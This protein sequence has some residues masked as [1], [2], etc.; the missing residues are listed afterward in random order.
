[1][2]GRL[3][4]GAP[5]SATCV[6]VAGFASRV[7]RGNAPCSG[8]RTAHVGHRCSRNRDMKDIG[9]PQTARRPGTAVRQPRMATRDRSSPA[10]RRGGLEAVNLILER[11]SC[12]SPRIDRPT[13]V[14]RRAFPCRRRRAPQTPGPRTTATQGTCSLTQPL[15]HSGPHRVRATPAAFHSPVRVHSE[16]RWR[17]E[18]ACTTVT[19]RT[20]SVIAGV[21]ANDSMSPARRPSVDRDTHT[22][23]FEVAGCDHRR[24][25]CSTRSPHTWSD[26]S[27]FISARHRRVTTCRRPP[28]SESP[29]PGRRPRRGPRRRHRAPRDPRRSP[30]RRR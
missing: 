22:R 30:S 6:V 1:M 20:L 21:S 23:P 7:R 27:G 14:H 4:C 15:L 9:A 28:R 13:R 19:R 3:R 12:E 24:A 11:G 8:C 10:L 16:T 26:S 29:K 5:G 25:A 2:S 18:G 17:R